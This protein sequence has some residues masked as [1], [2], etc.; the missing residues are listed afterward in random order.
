ML[1]FDFIQRTAQ[2]DPALMH[3]G[4]SGPDTRSISSSKWEEKKTVR[5]SP[6]TRV[7]ITASRNVRKSHHIG[8]RPE[9]GSSNKSRS[10]RCACAASNPAFAI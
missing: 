2:N 3:H 1:R 5:P 6:A 10:G 7:R 4:R 9:L 8:S